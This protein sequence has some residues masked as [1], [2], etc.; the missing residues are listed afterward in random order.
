MF[1]NCTSLEEIKFPSNSNFSTVKYASYLFDSCYKL[2]EIDLSIFDFKSVQY[3][4]YMFSN[5]LSLSSLNI[6]NFRTD[7]AISMKYMFY[8]LKS[9]HSLRLPYLNTANC[10][11]NN[12][13]GIFDEC[14]NI[15]LYVNID[16]CENLKSVVPDNVIIENIGE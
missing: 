16:M 6:E 8:S 7:N 14:D 5:C 4:D 9:L 12:L 15:V 3:F 13:R 11:N 2:K 10:Q 1:K